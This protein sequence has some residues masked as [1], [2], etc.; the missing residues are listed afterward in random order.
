MKAIFTILIF[1][2]SLVGFSQTVET[3]IN[4]VRYSCHPMGG[5]SG[6]GYDPI[7]CG[8]VA[9]R[10][11]FSRDEATRLCAG[12]RSDA[13]AQCAIK[14]YAGPFSKEES[15]SLCIRAYSVG[16]SECAVK[17]YAGPFSKEESLYLCGSPR[18]SVATA[19]CAIRAYSGPYSREES[20]RICKDSYGIHAKLNI[21]GVSKADF[22]TLLIQANEKAVLEGTY[23]K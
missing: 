4:G 19:D 13:P 7:A 9:Y 12:A 21:S 15:I 14:A 20:I 10:G 2:F 18:A 16:P 3:T 23:K 5:N 22:E 1:C 6:G 11:P 17:A 8:D